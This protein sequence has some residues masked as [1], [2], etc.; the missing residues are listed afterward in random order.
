MAMQYWQT[1]LASNQKKLGY[2]Y[3]EPCVLRV[4]SPTAPAPKMGYPL[5][6]MLDGDWIQDHIVQFLNRQPRPINYA[7]ASIGFGEVTRQIARQRRS[8]LY[9]PTPPAPIQAIDP[10]QPAWRCGGADHMLELLHET[11]LPCLIQQTKKTTII[12]PDRVGLYGHSYGGLFVLYT[13]LTQPHLFR[14]YIAASPSLWWYA[15][16]MQQLAPHLPALTQ[17]TRLDLLIGGKEQWRPKPADPS[18]PR[19]NGTLTKVFLD[20]FLAALP[21]PIPSQLAQQLRIYPDADHGTMLSLSTEF[22]L[23]EFIA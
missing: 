6:F 14:H 20:Q 2:P 21:K 23:S 16:F 22:A 4:W 1:K 5:L 7:I 19:P 8:Y 9:T 12:D 15:P 18:A 11:A 13:L 17:R 3:D 10:R